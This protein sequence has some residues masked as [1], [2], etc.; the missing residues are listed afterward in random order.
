MLVSLNENI[1][2]N[3]CYLRMVLSFKYL[4]RPTPI[5][6]VVTSN[7]LPGYICVGNA[8]LRAAFY[9][10]VN[11]SETYREIGMQSDF[12][13]KINNKNKFSKMSTSKFV[14]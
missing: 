13:T 2:S 4:F 14:K 1:Y 10:S 9:N 3:I 5:I 8:V 7:E 12:H 11:Y 6:L